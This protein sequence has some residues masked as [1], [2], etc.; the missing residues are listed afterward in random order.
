MKSSN[1]FHHYHINDIYTKY[2]NN[3]NSIVTKYL[4]IYV[5]IYIIKLT[6]GQLIYNIII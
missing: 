5:H 6:G 4:I 2:Q 3:R 1:D